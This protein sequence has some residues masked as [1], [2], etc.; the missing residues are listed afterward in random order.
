[1]SAATTPTREDQARHGAN[2]GV[3][4]VVCCPLLS[5]RQ[6]GKYP[7][8]FRSE[9]L[10]HNAKS[11]VRVALPPESKNG[12]DPPLPHTAAARPGGRAAVP[13]TNADRLE[14]SWGP[15]GRRFRRMVFSMREIA[16]LLD[17][18]APPVNVLSVAVG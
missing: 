18:Y 5:P 12:I 2:F 9:K 14:T 4:H 17:H 10:R 6:P 15:G 11:H 8:S 7:E 13:R 3:H 1:M 16:A